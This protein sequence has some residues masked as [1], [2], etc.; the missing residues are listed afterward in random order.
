MQNPTQTMHIYDMPLRVIAGLS[1]LAKTPEEDDNTS[2]GIVVSEVGKPITTTLPSW[3][4]SFVSYQLRAPRA[5]MTPDFLFGRADVNNAFC[6]FLPRRFSAPAVGTRLVVNPICTYPQYI[7]MQLYNYFHA[8]FHY[9]VHI[10]APLGTG[11]YVKI[12]APEL[13]NTTVTRGIRFK[14][15][16]Q[17][18]VALTVPWSNDISTVPV[19]TGRVG[20]SGGSI[21]IETI[22]DNSS[23]TVNSPLQ[24][25]VWCCMSNLKLTGYAIADSAGYNHDGMNFKPQTTGTRIE[26]EEQ[27]DN[28]VTAEGGNWCKNYCMI[29]RLFQ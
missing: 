9:I 22:E 3:C 21:I 15:S 27:A 8:D 12:Y 18:T 10:P 17:P 23:E 19:G 4:D 26:G 29:I 25:T 14:P 11:I 28:E 16:G 20:Q 7:M 6:A 5:E 2:T 1:T 13:D 24:I